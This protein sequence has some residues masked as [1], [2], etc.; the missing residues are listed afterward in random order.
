MSFATK[1]KEELALNDSLSVKDEL[2]ALFK[3]NGNLTISSNKYILKFVS[4][5]SKIAQKVYKEVF[6]LYHCKITTSISKKMKLRKATSYTILISDKVQVILNDLNFFDDEYFKKI[7]RNE[8]RI[9][10]YLAGAF[11]SSGSVNDPSTSNYHLEIVV[12]D[13]NYAKIIT[14]MFNKLNLDGKIIKRRNKFVIYL[15]K[16]QEVADFIAKV[17][18]TN[19][20]L[21]FENIRL[22]RDVLNN[23]NRIMNCDIYNLVRAN[24]AAKTQLENIAIIEKTIGL[25]NLDFDL[26]CLIKLRKENPED[27]LKELAIKFEKL[28]QKPIS[29][30][31]INHLFVKI[32]NLAADYKGGV[33][34]DK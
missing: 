15:K 19:C 22:S 17:G 4:E 28:T 21:D 27:S 34:N 16:A 33:D 20:Y 13:E 23:A 1:I 26:N 6:N 14:K 8:K 29:K 10:S 18:A 11:L 12:D 9:K 30:S 25:K 31:G 24:V 2:S 7:L 32:K 3:I 5:N